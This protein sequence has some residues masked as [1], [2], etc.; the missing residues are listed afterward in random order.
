MRRSKLFLGLLLMVAFVGCNEPYGEAPDRD[1]TIELEEGEVQ[2]G[3]VSNS[4]D[5]EEQV[6]TDTADQPLADW[7]S[8]H[9][10]RFNFCV[11]YPSNF[12]S[13]QGESENYDGNTFANANGSSE[14]R[15]SGIFNAL[16]E[17]TEEA[18]ERATENGTYY[19]EERNITYKRQ[20]DNWYVV[21]GKYYE[22]I[23]YARTTLVR[24]TFYTLY[25][26]YH[27]SEENKFSEIIKRNT[28]YFPECQ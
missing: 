27:P 11:S 25:F 4:G 3:T 7:K 19:E 13:P 8:Y 21:S 10:E 14:M 5:E 9:N 28:R 17:T 16:Y 1:E 22:S 2:E 26:E 24:D 18:F 15:A 12:L 6:E 23:F 20:R